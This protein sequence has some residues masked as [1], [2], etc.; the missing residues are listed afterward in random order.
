MSEKEWRKLS[1]LEQAVDGDWTMPMGAQASG[2]SV[3][4]F[5]RLRRVYEQA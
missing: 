1:A 4:L 3:R 2:L 5:R